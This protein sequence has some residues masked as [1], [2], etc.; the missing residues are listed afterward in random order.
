MFMLFLSVSRQLIHICMH[1][2]KQSIC[3]YTKLLWFLKPFNRA[4]N[5]H[6]FVSHNWKSIF[7]WNWMH[8]SFCRMRALLTLYSTGLECWKTICYCR[9]LNECMNKKSISKQRNLCVHEVGVLLL[10]IFYSGI[11]LNLNTVGWKL[12][13]F[14]WMNNNW[15]SMNADAWQLFHLKLY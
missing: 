8:D 6:S 12:E 7:V 1:I 14:E 15:R 13:D 3:G 2:Q 5:E 11:K 9:R 4:N 10:A